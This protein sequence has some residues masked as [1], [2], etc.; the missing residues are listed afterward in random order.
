[1][2]LK[3]ILLHVLTTIGMLLVM[4]GLNDYVAIVD[5]LKEN[6]DMLYNSV[7]II[8]GTIITLI[9]LLTDKFNIDEKETK[10]K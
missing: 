7:E 6:L 8:I 5:F 4:F 10:R 3:K 2:N 9:G 1:M